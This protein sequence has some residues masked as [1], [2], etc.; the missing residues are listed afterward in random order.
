M[1]HSEITIHVCIVIC[2]HLFDLLELKFKKENV[3]FFPV[4]V[5]P[6]VIAAWV[7]TSVCILIFCCSAAA[8]DAAKAAAA[9]AS[10][11]FAFR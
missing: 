9:A 4:S 11:S 3:H 5:Y 10:L 8:A 6:I 7:F 1:T 2:F